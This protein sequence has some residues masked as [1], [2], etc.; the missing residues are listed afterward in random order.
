MKIEIDVPDGL[1]DEMDHIVEGFYHSREEYILEKIRQGL[2]I[3]EKS[4]KNRKENIIHEV[5]E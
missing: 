5:E 4:S 3:D 2:V 1:L